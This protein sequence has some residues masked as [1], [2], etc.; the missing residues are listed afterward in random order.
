MKETSNDLE[1]KMQHKFYETNSTDIVFGGSMEEVTLLVAWLKI[2][3]PHTN[4]PIFGLGFTRRVPS[5][6]PLVIPHPSR[7]F[8]WSSL[9]ILLII[10]RSRP[11]N[12][13]EISH[14]P[15]HQVVDT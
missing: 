1:N 4:P 12:Q 8:S 14:F 9:S 10:Q 5:R 11:G 2:K 6:T 7:G 3:Y 13:S 15:F